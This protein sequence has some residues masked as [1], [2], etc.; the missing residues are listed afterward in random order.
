MNFKISYA[1]T[2]CDEAKELNKL[3]S[4]I[5]SHKREE[6]EIVVQVDEGN[7]TQ[8]VLSVIESFDIKVHLFPLN[9]DFASFKNNL[10]KLCKGDYIFQIDADEIPS[11][12]TVINLHK[13]LEANLDID[14]FL[15]PRVNI[16]N[17]LTDSH[18]KKWEWNLNEQNWINWPDY[19]YRIFKNNF[20][21]K[22]KNKV[23]EQITGVNSGVQLPATLDYAI[24]HI[25]DIK[26]QEKQNSKY[27][28]IENVS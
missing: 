28:Q 5:T 8:E 4:F 22:W 9:N 20:N 3:L 6:D 27:D 1:I 13:I 7:H 15:V 23:H 14:L 19:Q 16:V 17:G 21:I 11:D 12:E 25:K 2:V 24:M 10:K 26:K 18:L